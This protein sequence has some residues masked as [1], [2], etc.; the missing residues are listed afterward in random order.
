MSRK[1]FARTFLAEPGL[2][3]EL[4]CRVPLGAELN[5]RGKAM[6]AKLKR[7]NEKKDAAEDLDEYGYDVPPA[8]IRS[9]RLM[10]PGLFV[11]NVG[12]AFVDGDIVVVGVHHRQVITSKVVL[13]EGNFVLTTYGSI[14][15]LV[16]DTEATCEELVKNFPSLPF[17]EM[18][19]GT[20]E[21][22]AFVQLFNKVYPHLAGKN[23]AGHK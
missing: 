3:P 14:Y 13:R 23:D 1:V 16:G 9:Y 15:E 4:Q 18:V 11:K 21:Q 5:D 17:E 10:S 12:A 6:V 8:K 2:V 22:I 19:Q 7:L 20:P